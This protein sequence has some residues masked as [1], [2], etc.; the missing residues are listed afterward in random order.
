MKLGPAATIRD[1]DRRLEAANRLIAYIEKRTTQLT[2]AQA[3]RGRHLAALALARATRLYRAMAALTE[4]GLPDVAKLPLRPL[5]E[6]ILLGFYALYGGDEAYQRIRGAYVRELSNLAPE[7]RVGTEAGRLITEWKGPTDRIGWEDL[8]RIVGD[9]MGAS[10]REQNM[11][12][13]LQEWYDLLYRGES[14]TS[15]HAGVGSLYRYAVLGE[16]FDG[17][18]LEGFEPE[19]DIVGARIVAAGLLG[20]FASHVFEQFGYSIAEVEDLWQGVIA[21]VSVHDVIVEAE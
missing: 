15:V 4:A 17:V 19:E 16:R 10:S 1:A 12:K 2:S 3:Y 6:T 20:P 11:K 14:M 8:G 18:Q 9:L 5:Y 21:G 7:A 13:R